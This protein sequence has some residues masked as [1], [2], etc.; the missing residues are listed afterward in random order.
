[1]LAYCKFTKV[2]FM[3]LNLLLKNPYIILWI[4][5]VGSEMGGLN[6]ASGAKRNNPDHVFLR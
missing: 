6:P 4:F 2:I 1:M 3:P 5:F